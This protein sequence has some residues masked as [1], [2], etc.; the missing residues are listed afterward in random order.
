ME[1]HEKLLVSSLRKKEETVAN[2]ASKFNVKNETVLKEVSKIN[3]KHS[4]IID[5]KKST[6]LLKEKKI[7]GL[8][9]K[10]MAITKKKLLDEISIEERRLLILLKILTNNS[11]MSLY[12][13]S[14]YVEVSKNTALNDINYL[15]KYLKREYI[16]LN[17]SRKNSYYVGGDELE[18]RRIII[19]IINRLLYLPIGKLILVKLNYIDVDEMIIFKQRLERLEKQ[20]DITFSDESIEILPVILLIIIKRMKAFNEDNVPLQNISSNLKET[21]EY[22]KVLSIFWDYKSLTENDLEYLSSLIL[23]SNTISTKRNVKDLM[24]NESISFL[25]KNIN[26]F[27]E[28][29]ENKLA[30]KFINKNKFKQNLMQHLIPAIYRNILSINIINPITEQFILENRNIFEVVKMELKFIEEFT[31]NEFSD[32]EIAFIA[33]IVLSSI[34]S[35]SNWSDNTAFTAVVVCQ[36]GTSVSNLIREQLKDLFP[37]IEFTR[38]LS[39]R[40][41]ESEKIKEDFVF[42][43]IPL[44]DAIKVSSVMSTKQKDNLVNKVQKK[45][46]DNSWRKTQLIISQL[47]DYIDQNEKKEAFELL[48]QF[49]TNGRKIT[50]N[51]RN[52]LL[53]SPTQITIFESTIEWDEIVKASFKPM[54]NRETITTEYVDSAIMKFKQYYESQI[55]GPGVLLPHSTPGSGV[56]H[57]DVQINIFKEPI[58]SPKNAEYHI[59]IALAPDINQNHVPWLLHINKKFRNEEIREMIIEENKKDNIFELLQ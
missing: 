51:T 15:K 57:A 24:K 14:E 12:E 53:T 55:I 30:I 4:E 16:T 3:K 41:Y 7:S 40:Q 20:Y 10:K 35:N 49:F 56:K 8:T 11:Y 1:L 50:N 26:Y 25:Q 28:S 31:G 47:S 54:L 5:V 6:I 33:M 42:S 17:Y 9:Y 21:K 27:I 13:I 46:E 36:S 23:S 45:I 34:I 43:T 58:M 39:V 22:K 38:T 18:L 52:N 59:V 44:N 29:L 32:D 2:L 37:T 48:H 19:N